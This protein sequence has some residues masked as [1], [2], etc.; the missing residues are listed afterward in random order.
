MND[1]K[2]A[3]PKDPEYMKRAWARAM[4]KRK[5]GSVYFKVDGDVVTSH[6]VAE[7]LGV[8]R[9]TAVRLLK[10]EKIR[11]WDT[12]KLRAEKIRNKRT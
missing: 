7:K 8:S 3:F 12:L 10:N 5:M 4:A 1:K 11:D 6:Q 2:Y 9:T